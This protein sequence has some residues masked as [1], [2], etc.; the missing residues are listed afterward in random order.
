MPKTR[1]PSR[2]R[3][4][5][6]QTKRIKFKLG[7]RKNGV[8]ALALPIEELKKKLESNARPRDNNQLRAALRIRGVDV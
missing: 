2:K 3:G 6:S 8:S 5:K 4:G 7:G 1:V